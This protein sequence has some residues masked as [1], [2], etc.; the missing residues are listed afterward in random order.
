MHAR[1]RPFEIETLTLEPPRDDE[2]LVRLVATGICHTDIAV[3]DERDVTPLPAV[4]GHE[5]AGVVTSAGTRVKKVRPGD[6]VVLTFMSCGHCRQCRGGAP[7]YCELNMPL[8]FGCAREDGSTSARGPYGKVHDHFF[9]QSSFASYAIANERNVVKV[10][11]SAPLHLLGP[12][13][14]GLQ[15][16]AGAVMNSLRI[17]RGQ[18]FACFGVG[19]VGLA[20][21]MAAKIVGASTIIAVDVIA[22][23]LG[24]AAQLGATHIIDAGRNEALATL[25]ASTGGRGVDY[26]LETTGIPSVF[27]QAVDALGIKGT[28]GFVATGVNLERTFNARTV[29]GSGKRILGIVQGDSV[30]DKLIP[31]L[32][33]LHRRGRFPFEKMIRIYPFRRINEAFADSRSGRTVKP[34]I[35]FARRP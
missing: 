33:E 24:L 21:I 12:L 16:G 27:T 34:V 17:Q 7:A 2:V 5:G 13:G 6:H 19:P 15:T 32:I 30:P 31:T 8:N 22:S 4:L 14:C 9:G 35:R 11:K 23:R 18:T 26:S 28:C 25:K 3:R 1:A 20:A 29:L 10:P